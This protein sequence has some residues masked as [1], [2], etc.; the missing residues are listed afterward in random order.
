LTMAKIIHACSA[1]TSLELEAAAGN[2]LAGPWATAAAG[3]TTPYIAQ[4]AV[5]QQPHHISKDATPDA[6]VA[7]SDTSSHRAATRG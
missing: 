3:P 4:Y 2:W 6:A 5:A 7:V 1:C